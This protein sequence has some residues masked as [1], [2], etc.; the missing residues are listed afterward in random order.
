MKPLTDYSI[1]EIHE[2]LRRRYSDHV[3]LVMEE[4]LE[5]DMRISESLIYRFAG[6]SYKILGMLERAKELLFTCT[7]T[8]YDPDEH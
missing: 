7:E 2:E 1:Q 8:Q 6:S 5:E 4:D 3:L